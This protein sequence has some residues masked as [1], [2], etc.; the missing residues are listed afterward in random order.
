MFCSQLH[1]VCCATPSA[2]MLMLTSAFFVPRL[3]LLPLL[4]GLSFERY[5]FM[6]AHLVTEVKE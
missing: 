4:V 6:Y 2:I 3:S 1:P 5:G